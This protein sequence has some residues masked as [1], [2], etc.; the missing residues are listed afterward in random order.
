MNKNAAIASGTFKVWDFY[1]V[2]LGNFDTNDK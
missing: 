1:T 2:Q